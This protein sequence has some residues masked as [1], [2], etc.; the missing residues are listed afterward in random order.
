[1]DM[2]R[3]ITLSLEYIPYGKKKKTLVLGIECVTYAIVN[4]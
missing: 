1:M 4:P 2:H 3:V